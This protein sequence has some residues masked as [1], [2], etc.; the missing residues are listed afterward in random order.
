[1]HL[2]CYQTTYRDCCSA[3]LLTVRVSIDST[4]II[5]II[6][7]VFRILIGWR[8]RMLD[9]ASTSYTT[10]D[11]RQSRLV[12]V[13]Y[14]LKADTYLSQADFHLRPAGNTLAHL[15]ISFNPS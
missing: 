12:S 9:H 8:G 4:V 5:M 11:S 14:P 13:V 7:I 3:L 10:Q 15:D 1:M 6:I 2:K